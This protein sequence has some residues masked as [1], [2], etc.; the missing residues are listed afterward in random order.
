M[1]DFGT[2]VIDRRAF[3]KAGGATALSLA[4]GGCGSMSLDESHKQLNVFSWADYIHPDAIRIFEKRYGISVVYDTFA[5]NEALMAK[6]Q[7]GAANYDIVVPTSYI[8]SQLKRLKLLA[9]IDKAKLSNFNNLQPR[10]QNSKFDPG[11][12]YSI[13]YTWG[14]TGIGFNTTAFKN[15]VYPDAWDVFWD[16]RLA[17]RMT[18]LDDSRET[19][20]MALKRRGYSFNTTTQDPIKQ[21]FNEDRKS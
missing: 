16:K 21:A 10:F 6:L 20:G 11:C 4:L 13:P 15:G 2:K 1:R 14:T 8:L 17:H 5:S 19:I 18:L 3:L 7:A 9:P 12:G